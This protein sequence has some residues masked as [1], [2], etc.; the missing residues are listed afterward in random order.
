MSLSEKL[1]IGDLVQIK[2]GGP[3]MTVSSPQ[4]IY[5]YDSQESVH[6]VWFNGS[7]RLEELFAAE[8]LEKIESRK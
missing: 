4:G 3:R 1:Q 6:C 5:G 7:T 8:Y 2:S